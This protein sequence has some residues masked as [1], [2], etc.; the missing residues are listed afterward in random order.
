[1]TYLCNIVVLVGLV[2]E[3]RNML[4]MLILLE[5]WIWMGFYEICLATKRG[6]LDTVLRRLSDDSY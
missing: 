6:A 2:E 1:M 3:T 5:T 4:V